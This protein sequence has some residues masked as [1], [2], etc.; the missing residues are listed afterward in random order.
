MGVRHVVLLEWSDAATDEQKQAA[1]DGL[2]GLTGVVEGMR[3]YTAGLDLGVAGTHD[4]ALVVD[5][6]DEASLKEYMSHPRHMEVIQKYMA[7][8]MKSSSRCQFA[9]P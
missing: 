7:G 2:L 4:A 1:I 5:F 6:D 8:I 3:A 9:I